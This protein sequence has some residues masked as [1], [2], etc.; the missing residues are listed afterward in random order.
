[1]NTC[2]IRILQNPTSANIMREKVSKLT[3]PCMLENEVKRQNLNGSYYGHDN[4]SWTFA[5]IV[6]LL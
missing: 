5:D 1:M 2:C 4:I 3:K 6:S